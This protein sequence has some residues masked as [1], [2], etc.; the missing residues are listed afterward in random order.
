MFAGDRDLRLC[1][2]PGGMG[3]VDGMSATTTDGAPAPPTAGVIEVFA[4]VTCPFTHVGLRRLVRRRNQ[5]G[6]NVAV[7]VRAWPLELVNGEAL[8]ATLVE[9]EA[10]ALRGQVA[11]ELFTGLDS[12]HF[13][14]TSLPALAIA[15]AAYRQDDALGEL[16]SLE[17]RTALFEKGRDISSREVL[18]R[19]QA[20]FG[21]TVDAGDHEAVM[22]DWREGKRRG[23]KGSPH[24][25]A[26][27][28][29]AFCP[30]LD[31]RHVDGRL[32][33]HPDPEAL[34]E[35]LDHAIG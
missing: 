29:D 3:T 26:D 8:A 31:I 23:V 34:E 9:Q 14:E 33:I 19:L 30:S 17:L 20:A 4:D 6:S 25:F 28:Y 27:R 2:W 11:P 22:N 35:F 24:F 13:P 7:R 10:A 5:R 12:D 15:A 16:V 32:E 1:E 18:N 21:L